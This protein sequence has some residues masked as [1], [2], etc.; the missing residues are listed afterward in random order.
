[1][2]VAHSTQKLQQG[3]YVKLHRGHEDG[4]TR[5]IMLTQW[6]DLQEVKHVGV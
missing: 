6:G 4:S 3:F 1:M 2:M 5:C